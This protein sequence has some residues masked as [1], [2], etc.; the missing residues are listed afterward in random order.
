MRN[1]PG[2]YSGLIRRTEQALD[3][4]YR[5]RSNYLKH[6]SNRRKGDLESA[7]EFLESVMGDIKDI[8]LAVS[9]ESDYIQ[10]IKRAANREYSEIEEELRIISRVEGIAKH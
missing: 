4:T 10:N 1:I 3:Y 8:P 5:V 2:K 7:K 6:E 9:V